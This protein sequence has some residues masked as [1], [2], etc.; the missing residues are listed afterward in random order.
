MKPSLYEAREAWRD[1]CWVYTQQIE[2]AKS[3][4]TRRPLRFAMARVYDEKLGDHAAALTAYTG[5]LSCMPRSARFAEAVVRL[6]ALAG[7]GA[8]GAAG[9]LG[10]AV[11]PRAALGRRAAAGRRGHGALTLAQAGAGI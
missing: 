1:L 11:G 7:D 5:A 3:E 6:G 2:L 4:T 8:G 9:G 10:R